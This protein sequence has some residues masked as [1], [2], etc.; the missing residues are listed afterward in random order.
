LPDVGTVLP[1]PETARHLKRSDAMIKR[2]L[3]GLLVAL[4]VIV[5]SVSAADKA[6]R[7]ALDA[8]GR[9][10]IHGV[11]RFVLAVYDSGFG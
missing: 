1:R 9:L 5:A 4:L 10:L 7:T 3:L 6:P 8:Q 11:P 2:G